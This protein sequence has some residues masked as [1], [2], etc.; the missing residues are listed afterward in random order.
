LPNAEELE[1][2]KNA[3]ESKGLPTELGDI[4]FYQSGEGNFRIAKISKKRPAAI[5]LTTTQLLVLD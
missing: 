1:R 3:L 2:I 5:L 4:K